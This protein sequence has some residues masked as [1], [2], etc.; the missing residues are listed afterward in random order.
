[1]TWRP[2]LLT[3]AGL[4]FRVIAP[5]M[6]GYGGSTITKTKE[7]YSMQSLVTVMLLFLKHLGREEAIWAGHDWGAG[8]VWALLAHNPEAC[9][10]V[11]NMCL[12]YRTLEMGVDELIKYANRDL[13]PED[14]FPHAQWDYQKWY[15][16]KDDDG[17][18]S[19]FEK[20]VK[21]YEADVGN[22]LKAM[23]RPSSKR[24]PEEDKD[25]DKIQD[26]DRGRG[27]DQ[28]APTSTVSKDGGFFGGADKAPETD[29][30]DSLLDEE[31]LGEMVD[32]YTA[33][34]LWGPTAWYLNHDANKVWADDWS[35]NE[36]VVSVPTL[37][38]DARQDHVVGTYNSKI[39]RAMESFCRKHM[40][41]RIEAGH[42]VAL[43]Q[44]EQVNA[45][46][47]RWIATKVPR[48]WPFD[49][50]APL[51]ETD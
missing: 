33:G 39:K 8:L 21:M 11:V 15:E 27:Q 43:E 22:F 48:A 7:D 18:N 12:P 13:Y 30:A 1:M 28:R 40:E 44:P 32:A 24:V 10:G 51:M 16:A 29:I 4:G 45:A 19:N 34:G 20:A 37:F 23:F 9:S 3:F 26:Q 6:P 5:D 17:G 49:K 36:G 50:R 35:V 31:M 14:E 2:Q 47:A 41:V 46:I 25:K 42:W 38:V